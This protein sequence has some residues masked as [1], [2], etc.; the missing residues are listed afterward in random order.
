M[1]KSML[2]WHCPRLSA[3]G[4]KCWNED[5]TAWMTPCCYAS[6]CGLPSD[7]H[8]WKWY[9]EAVVHFTRNGR[10]AVGRGKAFLTALPETGVA[11]EGGVKFERHWFASESERDQFVVRINEEEANARECLKGE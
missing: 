6:P 8:R 9:Y 4:K 1:S 3:D 5:R 7:Y 11:V 10:V 2:N